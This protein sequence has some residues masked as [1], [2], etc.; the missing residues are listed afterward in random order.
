MA[1]SRGRT[2]SIIQG[3][4]NT[5]MLAGYPPRMAAPTATNGVA[6]ASLSFTTVA[7]ATSYT[8]ISNP[9]NITATGT[10]S[11]INVT[12]LTAGTAYTF[13]VSATNSAGTGDYSAASNSVTPINLIVGAL[14]GSPYTVA[15][16]WSGGFG[17]RYSNPA[18]LPAGIS[19]GAAFNRQT[20]TMA[21][22]HD[23]L[24]RITTYPFTV[25]GGYGTKFAD[26]ATLP[27]G[28]SLGVSFTTN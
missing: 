14:N 8:V 21:I 24:P 7:G 25:S 18:T 5:S 11:P 16:P 9:G 1:I 10:T 3:G 23:N 2:S 20:N 6:S 19:Y 13:R 22:C 26:P 15:Y 27:A 12:G 17:T 4:K 28:R